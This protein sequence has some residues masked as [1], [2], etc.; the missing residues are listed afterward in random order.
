MSLAQG[1][2]TLTQP[3]IEPGSPDPESDALTTRPVPPPRVFMEKY[4]KLSISY[5]QMCRIVRKQ[6]LTKAQISFAI[7][8]KLISAFVF[9]TEIVKSLFFVNTKFQASSQLLW[10]Y[11]PVCV[12]PGQKPRRLVFSERGSNMYCLWSSKGER[13]VQ[14]PLTLVSNKDVVG[15]IAPFSSLFLHH[16]LN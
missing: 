5:H 14:S 12:G 16:L 2:S 15:E 3:R 11:S 7:I 9:A 13:E 4:A 10:L 1:N 8:A 6:A